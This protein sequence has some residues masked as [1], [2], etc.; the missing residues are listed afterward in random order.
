MTVTC[1]VEPAEPLEKWVIWSFTQAE[2]NVHV[3]KK[4]CQEAVA[5]G[6][7]LSEQYEE[8]IG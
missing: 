7:A 1:T 4:G 2:G 6:T 3:E 8:Q 5:S